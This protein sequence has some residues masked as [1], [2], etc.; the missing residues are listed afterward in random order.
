MASALLPSALQALWAARPQTSV[1]VI[2]GP[3]PALLS[4]LAQRELDV[5]VGRF[6]EPAQMEGMTYEHLATESLQAV[7]R[8]GHPLLGASVGAAAWRRSEWIVPSAGTAIRL[9]ADNVL[10]AHGVEISPRL[11]TL[12]VSLA[13]QLVLGSDMVWITS[14]SVVRLALQQGALWAVPWWTDVSAEPVGVLMR[15]DSPPSAAMRA[16]LA[17]LKALIAPSAPRAQV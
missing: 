6:A 11:E 12:D 16:F 5:V 14:A 15:Q 10:R 1:Q 3:N 13:R 17:A 7:V 2:T 9:Q 8:P 4:R